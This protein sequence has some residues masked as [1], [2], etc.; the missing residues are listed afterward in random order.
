MTVTTVVHVAHDVDKVEVERLQGQ[1][2]TLI[3][4]PEPSDEPRPAA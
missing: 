2:Y 3:V 1:G 4:W